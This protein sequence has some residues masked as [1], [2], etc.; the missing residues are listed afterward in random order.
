[1]GGI[2]PPINFTSIKSRLD[3][4][5]QRIPRY[6]EYPKLIPVTKPPFATLTVCGAVLWL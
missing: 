2:H 4:L 3:G 6:V 5:N 1:M